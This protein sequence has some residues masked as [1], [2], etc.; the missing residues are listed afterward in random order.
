MSQEPS[1]STHVLGKTWVAFGPS[2]ALGSIHSQEDG[3]AVRLLKH[4]QQHGVYP[5]LEI[6]KNALRGVAGDD[7]EIREH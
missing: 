1:T 5:S 7:L 2:G 6:A 4:E 3:Y